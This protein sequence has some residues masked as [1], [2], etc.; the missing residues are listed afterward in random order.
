MKRSALLALSALVLTCTLS[1]CQ[2]VEDVL[3]ETS[4]TETAFWT[5]AAIGAVPGLVA[6]APVSIPLALSSSGDDRVLYLLAPGLPTGLVG[7]V[8]LGLPVLALESIV[9]LPGRLWDYATRP[10]PPRPLETHD[11]EPVDPHPLDDESLYQEWPEP[12]N[13]PR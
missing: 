4:A 10:D 11:P 12:R 13:V 9:R 8:A 7:G 1:G 5:G 2:G 6:F 3:D